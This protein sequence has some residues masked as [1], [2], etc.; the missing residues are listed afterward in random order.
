VLVVGY[1]LG[2]AK[3]GYG[4]DNALGRFAPRHP[5]TQAA[6]HVQ[7][8]NRDARSY[9]Q[10]LDVN[11]LAGDHM[12][13]NLEDVRI[14]KSTV[15]N[16]LLTGGAIATTVGLHNDSPEAA[17]AGAAAIL[18]GLLLK[19]NAH[20]DTTYCDVMPQRLY[21]V[22]LHLKSPAD[23]ITLQVEGQPG[24]QLVLTSLSPQGHGRGRGRAIL[25]YVALADPPT[26]QPPT[27]ATSGQVFYGNIHTAESPAAS[28][29]Y[30]LGGYD[31]RPPSARVLADYQAAGNLPNSTVADLLEQ[32]RRQGIALTREDQRGYAGLHLLEAGRS[33][34][35]PLPGTAG[36]ARLFGQTHQ[37][38]RSR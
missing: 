26:G 13:N 24:S 10:V 23:H 25:R 32:Y 7:I 1:G 28:L 21:L 8:N 15:G 18:T 17:I 6:L 2:P 16:V 35:A 12:W 5:S 33:L 38:Y 4:P 3:E 30:L 22:P 37:P 19:A 11:H 31:V 27:W 29:P 14:A 36:F 34:V 20:V 9:P